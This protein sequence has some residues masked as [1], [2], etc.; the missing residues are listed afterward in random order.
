MANVVSIKATDGSEVKFINEIRGAGAMKD[1]YFS[2]CGTYVV[3][4]FR[5]KQDYNARERLENIVGTYRERIFDQPGGDYWRGLFCWPTKIV[6]HEGKVG[7][8]APTY[9]KN[10]FFEFGSSKNDFLKIKGK[11]KEGKWF[12]SANHQSRHLDEAIGAATLRRVS[13]SAEQSNECTLPAWLIRTFPTRTCWS[14][15]RPE[16]PALSILTV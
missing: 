14:T 11:E 2:P 10:F 4:F 7:V 15:R 13:R 6:E 16:T 8:V 12:A 3:A 1:V 9:R 5:D